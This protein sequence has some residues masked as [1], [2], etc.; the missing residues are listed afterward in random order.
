MRALLRQIEEANLSSLGE[1]RTLHVKTREL[2]APVQAAL[3]EVGYKRPDIGVEAR[4]S[5]VMSDSG[6]AGYRAFAIVINLETGKYKI[7][8]GSWGGANMFTRNAV[9]SDDKSYPI[10]PNGAVVTGEEGGG[11]PVS[12]SVY[13]SPQ[14]LVPM[15]PSGAEL[16]DREKS[17]MRL[18]SYT[19]AY[20]KQEMERQGIEPAEVDA[21]V[22]RGLLKRSKAGAVSVTLAGKNAAESQ[23]G[24]GALLGRLEG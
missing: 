17:I 24:L 2:P 16:T 23:E 11:Q 8:Y 9:D 3:R 5:I 7:E 10:P 19:S 6:G 22:S 15:L 21:L 14:T 1:G 12:A 4:D 13:V 20:R 18:M